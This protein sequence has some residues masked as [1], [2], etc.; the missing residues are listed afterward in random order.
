MRFEQQFSQQQKQTQK[1][2]MTQQLQQS[3]QVLQF[4]TEELS[5]YLENQALENPLLEVS[6]PNYTSNYSKPKK[7]DGNE[8]DF[9]SQI[10]DTKLSLFEH[11][12]DQIHLNYRDT[13]LRSFVLYLFVYIY[14]N[15]FLI[16]FIFLVKFQIQIFLYLNI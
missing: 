2:A 11:L 4:T 3:I 7:Y 6:S 15:Y 14:F 10:P 5:K 16:N 1:L 9:L 8:L 13:Y 12:I